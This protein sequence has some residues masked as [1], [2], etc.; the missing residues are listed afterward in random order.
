VC[1]SATEHAHYLQASEILAKICYNFQ[2]VESSLKV[3]RICTDD[4]EASYENVRIYQL[5]MLESKLRVTQNRGEWC[6]GPNDPHRQVLRLEGIH[7]TIKH[8]ASANNLVSLLGDSIGLV[9]DGV[10]L[11]TFKMGY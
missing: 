3:V 5:V 6:L 2:R 7:R 8:R 11:C 9:I 1:S 4:C 10:L